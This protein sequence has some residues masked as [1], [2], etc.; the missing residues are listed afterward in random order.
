MI[1]LQF[2]GRSADGAELIFTN[3][4]GQRFQ[5]A[6]TDEL[7]SAIAL[8]TIAMAEEPS[9]KTPVS[10]GRIQSLLRS[11][12]TT[13][14][15]AEMTGTEHERV[16]RYFP[17]VAAE[18]NLAVTRAQQSRV[19]T[20]LDAPL[21]GDLVVDRLASRGIDVDSLSWTAARNEDNEWVVTLSFADDDLSR[22]AQWVLNSTLGSVTA[23]DS[24]ATELTETVAPPSTVRA[25][26]APASAV[27]AS[28][29][30]AHGLPTPRTNDMAQQE[31]LLADLNA[32]R[33]KRQV[34]F[35]D[36]DGLD[37]DEESQTIE[38]PDTL[39]LPAET[40]PAPA[41]KQP[42]EPAPATK[43]RRGRK[44]VPTWDEIV[45]GTRSDD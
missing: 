5:A 12:L 19:G 9:S 20:E 45:F 28:P 34:V 16:L 13:H 29:H 2:L 30:E 43:R 42:A 38:D 33:G 1:Q 14:E 37:L 39:P 4:E 23:L 15:V 3:D 40:P 26:F 7:R 18:I 17:P 41:S 11:G 10:P 22:T 36:I 27:P 24:A 6:I 44:P 8:A 32:A 25:L 35:E 21:M 31:K